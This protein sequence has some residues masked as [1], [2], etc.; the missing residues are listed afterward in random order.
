VTLDFPG[1][2]GHV[3]F[4]SRPFPGHIEWLPRRLMAFFEA[5]RKW[6]QVSF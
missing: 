2:G 5:G 6:G 1:R 3:G 4:V